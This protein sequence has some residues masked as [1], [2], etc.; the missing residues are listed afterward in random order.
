MPV[1]LR[2][3]GL[4][5]QPA[6]RGEH[7]DVLGEGVHHR[8]VCCRSARVPHAPEDVITRV[9]EAEFA[10]ESLIAELLRVVR[11]DDDNR[12]VPRT[13]REQT[14]PDPTELGVDLRDHPVVLSPEPAHLHWIRR[15][16]CPRVRQH[17]RVERVRVCGDRE[18]LCARIGVVHRAVL[19]GRRER[20]VRTEVRQMREPRLGG[21]TRVQP[22]EDAVGREGGERMCRGPLVLRAERFHRVLHVMA[23]RAQPLHPRFVVRDEQRAHVESGQYA[24]ERRQ[25]RVVT[26]VGYARVDPLVRVSK[27]H[28]RIAG[29]T[30]HERHVVEPRV[31]RGAVRDHAMV[32]LVH[33]RVQ[34]GTPG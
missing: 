25:P 30:G 11:R 3:H 8:S 2:R 5:D 1:H 15:C 23:E 10:K 28:G 27:Q 19:A 14:I 6:Q 12:V 4:A 18:R 21:T 16:G 33:A 17:E 22:R 29:A 34:R 31:E 32:H 13:V 24:L 26:P 7:V 20:R 9:E